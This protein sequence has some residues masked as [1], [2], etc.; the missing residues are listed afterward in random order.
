MPKAL[1]GISFKDTGSLLAVCS[2]EQRTLTKDSATQM[3][4]DLVGDQLRLSVGDPSGK[5]I[6]IK[7][8]FLAL[9]EI[10]GSALPANV[11]ADLYAYK[12]VVPTGGALGD[13]TPKEISNASGPT[14]DLTTLKLSPKQVQVKM[15]I[16]EGAV[17]TAV[18]LVFQDLDPSLQLTR[19]ST[20]DFDLSVGAS[21]SSGTEYQYA[22]IKP[23]S[24]IILASQKPS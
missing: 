10:K 13:G 24:P 11:L 18:Y 14:L 16:A 1:Y 20:T 23:N 19:A 7:T 9:D 4:Q 5:Q 6:Q 15:S 17:G 8:E 12:V 21:L 22:I 2:V 3:L